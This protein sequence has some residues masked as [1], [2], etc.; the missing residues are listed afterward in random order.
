MS[1]PGV[2]TLRRAHAV[3][4]VTALQNEYSLWW[5]APETNG[6]LEAC[7]E[8]GIGFVPYS[9]L[10]KGFLTGAMNKDTEAGENDFRSN[11]RASSRRR[12]RR[13]KRL[14][15]SSSASPITRALRPRRSRLRGCSPSGPGSCRSPARPVAPT[16]REYR[17]RGCAADRQ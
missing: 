4:P 14:S 9:P 10:G 16:R 13:T 6:I 17:R 11:S 8:L 7:D 5:R 1:E 3:Q 2:Q 12:W 15:T